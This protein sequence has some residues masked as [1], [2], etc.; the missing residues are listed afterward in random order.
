MAIKGHLNTVSITGLLQLLCDENKTGVLRVYNDKNQVK[1]FLK[2]GAILCVMGTLP[3]ARLGTIL[4]NSNLISKNDLYTCLQLSKIKDQTLG[5][6]L[7]DEGFISFQK[8]AAVITKQ[9]EII[10]SDLISWDNGIFEYK[11][12]TINLKNMIITP[13]NVMGLILEASR[14]RDELAVREEKEGETKS[15]EFIEEIDANDGKLV[16]KND[17][18]DLSDIFTTE[19]EEI[20]D[21]SKEEWKTFWDKP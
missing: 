10:I 8:L 2:D 6:I 15:Q 16:L 14:Q 4:E 9:A 7:I 21:I 3:K 1:F 5:K 19:S 18:A 20:I 13:I 17:V 12:G 11:D